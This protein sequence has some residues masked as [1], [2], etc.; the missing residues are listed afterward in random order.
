MT[1][2]QSQF[3]SATQNATEE[4][5]GQHSSRWQNDLSFR[6]DFKSNHSVIQSVMVNLITI[7]LLLFFDGSNLILRNKEDH[8]NRWFHTDPHP[9]VKKLGVWK[10]W[11][12]GETSDTYLAI[13]PTKRRTDT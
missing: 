12:L 5:H 7:H 1:P 4:S 2:Q 8:S 9:N 3:V 6:S 10:H 11:L 13:Q